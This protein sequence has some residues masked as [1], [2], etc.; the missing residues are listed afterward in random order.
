MSRAGGRVLVV[1]DEVR[2][3]EVLS[4]D[5]PGLDGVKTPRRVRQRDG[6][7]AVIRPDRAA[8]GHL[9]GPTLLLTLA[10]DLSDLPG[11]DRSPIEVALEAAR[12]A[13]PPAG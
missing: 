13:L 8:A 6:R 1:D 7:V 11:S 3:R 9:D 10:A 12:R 4:E 2:V 5:V